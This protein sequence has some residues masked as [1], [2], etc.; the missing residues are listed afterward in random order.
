MS[1]EYL[2]DHDHADDNG[3][4]IQMAMSA[5][6]LADKRQLWVAVKAWRNL[7]EYR[8]QDHKCSNSQFPG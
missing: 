6:P 8:N 5:D 7:A 3:T 1:A 4:T 2:W